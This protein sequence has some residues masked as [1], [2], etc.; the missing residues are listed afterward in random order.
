MTISFL[1]YFKEVPDHRVVGM[2]TYPLDEVL[3]ATLVG[4]LCG[5]DEWDAIELLS[6]EYLTWLR[7]FLPYK[8]GVPSAQTFRKIFRLLPP[9]LL[10]DSFVSW[11]ASL[12]EVV[13]GVVAIDGKALRGSKKAA[14]GSGMA[15]VLSAYACDAGLVLGQRIVDGKSNEINVI[16]DLLEMLALK[17]AIVSIDAMG[18]QKAIAAKVV[19]KEADY[20]LALKGNQTTLHKEVEASFRDA[21]LAKTCLVHKTKDTGHGRIE[22]R[23]C[24]VTD[25]I[26]ALKARHP[27][28]KNLRTI[29]SITSKRIDRKTGQS[30][31]ETRFF[32][33]SLDANPVLILAASRAHWGIENNLHWQLDITFREDQCRTRKDFSA[34]NLSIVRHL[35]FNILKRD[36]S[37][38]SLKRKR[39][40]ASVNPSFRNDLLAR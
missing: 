25:R 21:T 9:K 34:V 15:H 35:A 2:V 29:A 11:V 7:R 5:A 4:V 6:R 14:D 36:A 12:Q 22:E 17:G 1:D 38:L 28:W 27:D 20:L 13:R 37:K 16:P 40:K 32:I 23:E 33:T 24:L 39:L 26:D 18:T 19:E 8:S 31:F 3:L 10:E 30:S